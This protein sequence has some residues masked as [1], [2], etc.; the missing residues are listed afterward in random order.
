[1][2]SN[3]MVNCY[4]SVMIVGTKNGKSAFMMDP[5]VTLPN[6][7]KRPASLDM[8]RERAIVVRNMLKSTDPAH[9]WFKQLVREQVGAWCRVEPFI[10]KGIAEAE[11]AD[12]KWVLPAPET[13]APATH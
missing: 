4:C 3:V 6:P 2:V 13:P 8:T 12:T 9:D 10:F 11:D 1:M 7:D 5:H